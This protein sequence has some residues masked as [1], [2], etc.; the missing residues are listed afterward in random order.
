MAVFCHPLE[1][2]A[3]PSN[4]HSFPEV[5]KWRP[6]L[7]SFTAWV[8]VAYFWIPSKNGGHF[9]FEIKPPESVGL[10]WHH[11]EWTFDILA[12]PKCQLIES[13]RNWKI[14]RIPFLR[15]HFFA[16][17]FSQTGSNLSNNFFGD[18]NKEHI[19]ETSILEKGFMYKYLSIKYMHYQVF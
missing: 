12:N 18:E 2:Y 6:I 10:F 15:T 11:Q 14:Q 7:L 16:A 8:V 1:T 17:H 9:W 3:C 4:W 19:F 5:T 13:P